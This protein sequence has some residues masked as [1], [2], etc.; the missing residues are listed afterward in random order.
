MIGEESWLLRRRRGCHVFIAGK[1]AEEEE[2]N[3]N[4]GRNG[5]SGILSYVTA[6]CRGNVHDMGVVTA[7]RTGMDGANPW[8]PADLGN[9]DSDF[10]SEDEPG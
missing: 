9:M 10:K 8:N 7:R 6:T 2:A 1:G 5:R 4:D 3:D